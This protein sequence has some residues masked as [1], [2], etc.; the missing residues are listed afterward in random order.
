MKMCESSF[1]LS[2]T[3]SPTCRGS[4]YVETVSLPDLD[5]IV[6]DVAFVQQYAPPE[7]LLLREYQDT[8]RNLNFD[9]TLQIALRRYNK[10]KRT[11]N[12]NLKVSLHKK[13]SEN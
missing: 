5:W 3:A 7:Q 11:Y 4:V 2:V 12:L 10:V 8:L 9:G 6:R 13:Q 1:V